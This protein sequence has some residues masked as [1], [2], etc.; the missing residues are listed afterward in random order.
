[1]LRAVARQM[2]L[3]LKAMHENHQ[4]HRDVKPGNVLIDDKVRLI[5]DSPGRAMRLRCDAMRCIRFVSRT[6]IRG[7]HWA[8]AN[9]C[10]G[11]PISFEGAL[12]Y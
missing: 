5:V 8:R 6:A 7:W 4:V 11:A 3:G 10:A 2:L 1:M 12:S 9:E